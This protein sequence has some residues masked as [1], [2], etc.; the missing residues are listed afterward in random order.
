MDNLGYLYFKD[1][2]GDT[3]RW[4]GENVSTTEVESVVHNAMGLTDAT[5]YGVEI[6][7][8]PII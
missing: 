2:T 4:K 1:R 8:D 7:G 3:F 6:P 5:V